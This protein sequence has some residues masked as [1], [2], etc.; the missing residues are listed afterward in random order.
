MR[1]NPKMLSEIEKIIIKDK[2]KDLQQIED[3]P[4]CL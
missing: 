3:R 1:Q 2:K 4:K